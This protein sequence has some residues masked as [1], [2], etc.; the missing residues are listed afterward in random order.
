MVPAIAGVAASL[1]IIPL[2]VRARKG[3]KCQGPKR[4]GPKHHKVQSIALL[5]LYVAWAGCNPL[6]DFVYDRM[7]PPVLQVTHLSHLHKTTSL[8]DVASFA[9]PVCERS[10]SQPAEFRHLHS[11]CCAECA[12]GARCLIL[13]RE[14]AYSDNVRG[15]RV[16]CAMPHR[17]V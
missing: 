12:I 6:H 10:S 14:F 5:Q 16:M 1:S 8:A 17:A 7:L 9:V 13:W 2:Q 11:T 3:S 4:Q 15:G